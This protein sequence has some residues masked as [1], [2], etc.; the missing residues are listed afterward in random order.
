[1]VEYTRINLTE[2][3]VDNIVKWYKTTPKGKIYPDK[4]IQDIV[5]LMLEERME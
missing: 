4:K 3:E 2:K 1:M 5:K